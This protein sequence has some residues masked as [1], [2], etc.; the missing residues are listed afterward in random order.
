MARNPDIPTFPGT[1]IQLRAW[2]RDT[3]VGRQ[4]FRELAKDV[5]EEECRKCQRLRPYPKVLIVARRLRPRI[6]RRLY[7]IEVFRERGVTVRVEELIDEHDDATVEILAQELLEAQLPRPWRHL[8][9]CRSE[10]DCFRGLT[11]QRRLKTLGDLEELRIYR[12]FAT[13]WKGERC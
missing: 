8:P 13:T 11:A 9:H 5:L 10:S 7:G 3:I 2:L 1:A 6:R 12:E 4:M